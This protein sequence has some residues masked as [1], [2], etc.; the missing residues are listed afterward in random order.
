MK[1][2]NRS[3]LSL[4]AVIFLVG[5]GDK[6][7]S[8]SENVVTGNTADTTDVTA[9]EPPVTSDDSSLTDSANSESTVVDSQTK[10]AELW[11]EEVSNLML[12]HLDYVIPYMEIG[13]PTAMFTN[14]DEDYFLEVT[15]LKGTMDVDTDDGWLSIFSQYLAEDDWVIKS[16]GSITDGY[17]ATKDELHLRVVLTLDDS[18]CT[19]RCYYDEPFDKTSATDW[20][21]EVKE[22]IVSDL[23]NHE[24]PFFYMGKKTPVLT[25]VDDDNYDFAIVGGV[26]NSEVESYA[27]D[28]FDKAGYTVTPDEYD[29]VYFFTAQKEFGDGDIVKVSL[30]KTA[31]SNKG[32]A[33]LQ[34]RLIKAYK[35]SD[36]TGAWDSEVQSSMN[37]Y[38]GRLAPYF[39]MG[40]NTLEVGQTT[41]ANCS[42]V[43]SGGDYSEEGITSIKTQLESY[44]DY[45]WET[46]EGTKNSLLSY[47]FVGVDKTTGDEWQIE[48][49]GQSTGKFYA[50]IVFLE[51]YDS[52]KGT[53]WR[54][55][56]KDL[57]I[58]NADSHYL[59]Y[60]FVGTVGNAVYTSTTDVDGGILS[61]TGAKW[62]DQIL[63][64]LKT[65]FESD[66]TA[67]W[68]I[69]TNDAEN[70]IFEAS[71]VYAD[72]CEYTNI[73]VTRN[74]N[75]R[76]YVNATYLPKFS[77]N[78]T[79]WSSDI[80]KMFDDY[81]DGHLI[82]FVYLNKIN[83]YSTTFSKISNTVTI[84][85]GNY[86]EEVYDN[87]YKT[88]ADDDWTLTET[89]ENKKRAI[90][91][92]TTYA[93]KCQMEVKLYATALTNPTF[94]LDVKYISV[95]DESK[96]T[97][98]TDD[99]KALMKKT[100]GE[101]PNYVYVGNADPSVAVVTDYGQ[102]GVNING[103]T[104]S[105]KAYT[106]FDN[107]VDTWNAS[108]SDSE[109]WKKEVMTYQSLTYHMVTQDLD[110]GTEKKML[111]SPSTANTD[112]VI[113]LQIFYFDPV[114]SS[115]KTQYDDY[116]LDELK[117]VLPADRMIPYF[118]LGEGD[119]EYFQITKD[120]SK[121]GPGFRRFL[122]HDYSNW[123]NTLLT[124]AKSVLEDDG[125]TVELNDYL[126]ASSTSLYTGGLKAVKTYADG[127][128]TVVLFS[129]ANLAVTYFPAYSASTSGIWSEEAQAMMKEEL[130]GNVLPYVN[131]GDVSYQAVSSNTIKT[132]A[133][134]SNMFEDIKSAFLADTTRKW[135]ATYDYSN[136]NYGKKLILSCEDPSNAGHY[137]TV[138]FYETVTYYFWR[139]I[140]EG[141]MLFY[142]N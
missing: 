70:D 28:A 81:M 36:S 130:N 41:K 137:I 138:Y 49:Y 78:E 7:S 133:F 95:F 57:F 89:T 102:K 11:G 24:L 53:V 27:K 117:E 26:W 139:Y 104:W 100:L 33:F 44:T 87:F 31:D 127:A 62:D 115:S 42:M 75:N 106:Y 3:L 25:E 22:K 113:R 82:P 55:E 118:E 29:D 84:I 103:G 34:V 85:G 17:E 79:A 32:R 69:T 131:L 9:T 88:Y 73:K 125:Y 132:Y 98:W 135:S 68:T 66:E 90:I 123:N 59:P 50:N 74:S 16:E 91:A 119:D 99:T 136:A 54:Q 23:D 140:D 65:A 142:Y 47:T 93:D 108:L 13:R 94:R 14:E 51:S 4:L 122:S 12:A 52:N 83:A 124:K 86:R 107:L 110:D 97:D 56:I 129:R 64:D 109:K 60:F 72:G 120:T 63:A 76:I 61:F 48:V 58:A 114:K 38:F 1:K 71:G 92:T 18:F 37:E 121:Y 67:T 141:T 80:Q 6:T 101:V 5:C 15:G 126:F 116:I 96:A 10:Y 45:T 20:P 21:S 111:L 134:N 30:E 8:A 2:T 112:Q 128:R 46:T 40:S 19:L 43:L 39:Y 77:V 105:D 35:L